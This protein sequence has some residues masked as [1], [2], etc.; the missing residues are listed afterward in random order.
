MV[1]P[2]WLQFFGLYEGNLV[3]AVQIDDDRPH[4]ETL[5]HLRAGSV[6]VATGA[7]ETQLLFANNDLPG[8]MLRPPCCGCCINMRLYLANELS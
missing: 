5:L 1:T 6:V 4:A 8:V 2:S 3:G 7:Y